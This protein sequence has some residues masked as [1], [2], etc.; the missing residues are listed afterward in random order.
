MSLPVSTVHT[1]FHTCM[2]VKHIY[3]CMKVCVLTLSAWHPSHSCLHVL[4]LYSIACTACV[5]DFHTVISTVPP[6]YHGVLAAC[7]MLHTPTQSQACAVTPVRAVT[8][9]YFHG[10]C[11]L[12]THLPPHRPTAARCLGLPA[13]TSTLSPSSV[14][15]TCV[16]GH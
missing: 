15:L 2:S 6:R 10:A 14:P 13:H 4:T 1:H 12:H 7:H 8:P 11:Y 5:Y 16:W 3:T 9:A